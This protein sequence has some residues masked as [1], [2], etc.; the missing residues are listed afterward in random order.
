LKCKEKGNL[1]TMIYIFGLVDDGRQTRRRGMKVEER[2]G[3]SQI[4]FFLL[5]RQ[6][7]L[8]YQK[9]DSTREGTRYYRDRDMV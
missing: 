1:L 4:F 5:S 7:E 2:A 8:Y 9:I 6:R 3:R